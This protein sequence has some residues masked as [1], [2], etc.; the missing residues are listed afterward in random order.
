[1]EKNPEEVPLN[2]VIYQPTTIS[3]KTDPESNKQKKSKVWFVYAAAITGKVPL[4]GNR[5]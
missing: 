4:L 5:K 1:M 2:Q 3:N